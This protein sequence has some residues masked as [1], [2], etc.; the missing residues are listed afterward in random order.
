MT[1]TSTPGSL[2][3]SI[4]ILQA[5]CL[6]SMDSTAVSGTC[7]ATTT[8]STSATCGDSWLRMGETTPDACRP[9]QLSSKEVVFRVPNMCWMVICDLSRLGGDDDGVVMM[10]VFGLRKAGRDFE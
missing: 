4:V 6:I 3:F 2:L 9:S 8:M 7:V 5:A 10:V 1:E